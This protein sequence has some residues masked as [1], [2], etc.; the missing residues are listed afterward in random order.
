M[1]T[2]EKARAYDE[3]IKVAKGLF[4]SPRTCFDIDQLTNI[5]PQLAESED[6]RIG[7][8]I[9]CI[10]R[11]N[12]EVKRILDGNGISVDNAL[13]Y[14]EKQKDLDKMIVVSPEVWDK[15]IADAY[16]NGKKDGEKKKEQK[17]EWSEEIKQ[18]TKNTH[19]EEYPSSLA[20]CISPRE[21]CL[22]KQLQQECIET[23]EQEL[24]SLG[25]EHE[26]DYDPRI[27]FLKSLRPSWKPSEEQMKWLRDVIETV[28]MTCRQQIPLESLYNDLKKLK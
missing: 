9:Y 22:F 10:V 3:A 19:P 1:T 18:T 4:N 24:Y 26:K 21:Y 20:E 5:F 27:K 11:D 23:I 13:A 8:V 6:E 14:L 12:K 15:A 25:K 28:P 16:E 2:E 17:P 7:N